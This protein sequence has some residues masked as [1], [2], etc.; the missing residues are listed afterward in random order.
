MPAS[1]FVWEKALRQAKLGVGPHGSSTL[2]AGFALASFADPDGSSIYPGVTLLAEGL[3]FS[4]RTV[5]RALSRLRDEGYLT[6]VREG[7]SRAGRADE[8]RL[9]LP[10]RPTA[11]S[12]EA[13]AKGLDH[14]TGSS[15]HPTA[16]TD[17]ST[18]GSGSSDARVVPPD[19]L[20][21]HRHQTIHT[22]PV[23]APARKQAIG[24]WTRAAQEAERNGVGSADP[25]RA[26]LTRPSQ[27]E[28][29]TP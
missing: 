11:T 2:A 4:T 13:P 10:V 25:P 14:P 17:H 18:A 16:R 6:K 7:N 29:T 27:V 28:T 24:G 23:P 20:P 22:R 8:Y 12:G 1:R 3:G 26:G 19:Q 15:V 9:S 21:T 5:D